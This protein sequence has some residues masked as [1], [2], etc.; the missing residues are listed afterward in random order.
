[1]RERFKITRQVRVYTAQ[2]RLTMAILMALPPGLLVVMSFV[3]RDFIS[4]LYLDPIGRLL[5]VIGVVLQTC[6]FFLIRRII[7][8]QV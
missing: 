4:V 8:I 7:H 3:N 2:G 1:V 6:G 5:I